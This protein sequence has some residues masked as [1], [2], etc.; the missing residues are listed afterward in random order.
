MNVDIEDINV[1]IG[2]MRIKSS[3]YVLSTRG[4]GSCVGIALYDNKLKILA[5][6]KHRESEKEIFKILD[7]NKNTTVDEYTE[8]I[9]RIIENLRNCLG[10]LIMQSLI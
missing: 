4:L 9:K 10:M 2:D 1:E 8:E 6:Q 5:N 3:P 7:I